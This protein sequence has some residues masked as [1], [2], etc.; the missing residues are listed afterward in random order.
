MLC[1]FRN[2][3]PVWLP[4]NPVSQRWLSLLL[5]CFYLSR[6]IHVLQ[7]RSRGEGAAL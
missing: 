5:L 7:G 1:G 6:F 3:T 2:L 4:Q